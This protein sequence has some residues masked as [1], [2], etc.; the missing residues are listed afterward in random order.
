MEGTGEFGGLKFDYP[1]AI[2]ERACILH[3]NHMT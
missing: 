3:E 1:Q 2:V